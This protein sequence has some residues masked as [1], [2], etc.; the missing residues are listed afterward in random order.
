MVKTLNR[1][2]AAPPP[3]PNMGRPAWGGTDDPNLPSTQMVAV[4]DSRDPL[5]LLT[6]SLDHLAFTSTPTPSFDIPRP[7]DDTLSRHSFFALP[8]QERQ[9]ASSKVAYPTSFIDHSPVLLPP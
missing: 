8:P 3:H 6:G 2:E 4:G 1:S 7:R 9:R 5:D